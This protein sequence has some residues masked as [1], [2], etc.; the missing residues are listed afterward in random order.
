MSLIN[1][2]DRYKHHSH[3]FDKHHSHVL[4][5][6][7]RLPVLQQ[8]GFQFFNFEIW[9]DEWNL[10]IANV[11]DRDIQVHRKRE[12]REVEGLRQIGFHHWEEVQH[13][14]GTEFKCWCRIAKEEPWTQKRK[15]WFPWQRR[16]DKFSGSSKSVLRLIHSIWNKKH[17]RRA[18]E[19][20]EKGTQE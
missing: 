10:C 9:N 15:S 8:C 16:R 17:G 5:C 14:Q 4:D 6:R 11:F 3:V 12:G 13:H 1:W 19:R 18:D 20:A 7:K 2:K